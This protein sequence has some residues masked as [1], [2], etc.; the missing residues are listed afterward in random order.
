MST[1]ADQV[2]RAAAVRHVAELVDRARICML[3]T[4]TVDGRHVS[5]PMALQDVEFDGDLWFFCDQGS[6]KVQQITRNPSVNVSFADAKHS[7]WTS[8]AGS[9]EVVHDRE[10]A[11]RLWGEPLRVWFPDGLE[12]PGITLLKV[13][14]ESAEWWEAP[15]SRARQLLG[16]VRAVVTKDPDQ[17]PSENGSIEL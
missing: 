12:T 17:F 13:H 14:A 11:E 10:Q 15:T 16:A 5:R 1:G 7:E 8:V 6:A 3:T 9:A 4:T 2:D